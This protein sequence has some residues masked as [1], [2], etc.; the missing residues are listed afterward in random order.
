MM[1]IICPG[2]DTVKISSVWYDIVFALHVCIYSS[3]LE[4]A[5]PYG[6][7]RITVYHSDIVISEIIK[8]TVNDT[9]VPTCE[10]K[11]MAA[12]QLIKVK[13]KGIDHVCIYSEAARENFLAA[14]QQRKIVVQRFFTGYR[15]LEHDEQ[16]L[17]NVAQTQTLTLSQWVSNI[18]IDSSVAH[19]VYRWLWPMQWLMILRDLCV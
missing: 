11:I 3:D 10:H 19:S 12:I 1:R 8:H 13:V 2:L 17:N 7:F 9:H 6:S 4:Q 14:K 16:W 18:C 15:A 5:E